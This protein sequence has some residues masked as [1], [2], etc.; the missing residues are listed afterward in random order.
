MR[1][2]RI[3]LFVYVCRMIMLVGGLKLVGHQYLDPVFSSVC[4]LAHSWASVFKS[5]R[6]KK[7][8]CTLETE[9][10]KKNMNN[11]VP[12]VKQQV[13]IHEADLNCRIRD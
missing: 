13:L 9:D 6:S 12:G 7:N 3:E 4:G 8:F 1:F 2:I 5:M 10:I 11:D